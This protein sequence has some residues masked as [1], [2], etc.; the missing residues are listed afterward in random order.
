[1]QKL[2][3]KLRL[4]APYVLSCA[5]AL[6]GLIN[7]QAKIDVLYVFLFSFLLTYLLHSQQKRNKVFLLGWALALFTALF[8]YFI[9]RLELLAPVFISILAGI[10]YFFILRNTVKNLNNIFVAHLIIFFLISSYFNSY[11][12]RS[13]ISKEPLPKSYFNDYLGFLRNFYLVEKGYS[14]YEGLVITHTEDGRS[15]TL[16]QKVWN[17]RLPTYAYLWKIFPGTGGLSVYVF[18]LALSSTALYFTYQIGRVFLSPNQA[19]LVPYVLLPYFHFAARDLS[20]LEMEWWALPFSIFAVFFYLKD[21]FVLTFISATF[22]L[23]LRELFLIPV[24]TFL[25]L[26]IFSKNY[27]KAMTFFISITI[28]LALLGGHYIKVTSLIPRTLESFRPDFQPF[29]PYIFQQTLSYGSVDYLFFRFRPFLALL[30]L[31]PFIL[32]INFYRRKIS[33]NL[34]LIPLTALSMAI[35]TLKFASKDADY[36]GVTYVPLLLISIVFL[37]FRL[38]NNENQTKN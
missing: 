21:R 29:D 3:R 36:W 30:I 14:Y 35:F 20:F 17:W 12:L 7:P 8:A 18:F 1:M 10:I 13:E 32:A 24:V 4:F 15:S 33:L 31:T 38:V 9:Y 5:F 25:V 2:I 34:L 23:L 11:A 28:I 22:A 26:S 37:L 19:V 27:K 16:P 6:F